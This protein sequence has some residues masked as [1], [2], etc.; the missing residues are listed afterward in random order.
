MHRAMCAAVVGA[1]RDTK[2]GPMDGWVVELDPRHPEDDGVVGDARD[3]KLDALGMRADRELDGKGIVGDVAGGDGASIGN[4][5]RSWDCLGTESDGVGLGKVGVD[6]R[7]AGATV[8]HGD[9]LDLRAL[10][11]KS[12]GKNE[13]VRGSGHRRRNR[14]AV[15]R[16]QGGR[17][18]C[19]LTRRTRWVAQKRILY[20][21]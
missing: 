15:D 21:L 19:G 17:C 5:Q 2:L 18:R 11:D 3:F 9:S 10:R 13:E 7:R 12:N 1:E 20:C 4:L 16:E 8:D 14:R 6:E